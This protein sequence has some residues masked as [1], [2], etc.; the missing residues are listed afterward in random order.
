MD[1]IVDGIEAEDAT[2]GDGGKDML[3]ALRQ[4][5]RCVHPDREFRNVDNYLEFR[6]ENVGAAWEPLQNRPPDVF[7]YTLTNFSHPSAHRFIIAA[8]KFSVKSS[9]SMADPRFS[10]YFALISDHLSLVNDLASYGKELRALKQ[11]EA[12]DIINLVHVVKTITSLQ[13]TDDA[14]AVVWA[15]QLQIEKQMKDELEVSLKEGGLTN[16]EWWFLEAATSAAAGM[17]FFV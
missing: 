11:S 14:K 12:S 3:G 1:G 5:F 6:R 10:H 13:G 17:S 7:H 2:G 4:A 8:A 9:A 15:L 16:D